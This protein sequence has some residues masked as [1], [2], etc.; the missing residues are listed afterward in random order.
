MSDEAT[1]TASTQGARAW[2]IA[3]VVVGYENRQDAE[4]EIPSPRR[5]CWCKDGE[6]WKPDNR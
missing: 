5:A 4:Y 3:K 2:K 6:Q 1:I